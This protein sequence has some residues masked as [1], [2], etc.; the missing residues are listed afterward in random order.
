MNMGRFSEILERFKFARWS[1]TKKIVILTAVGISL[2]LFIILISSG[3]SNKPSS[4]NKVSLIPRDSAPKKDLDY[5]FIKFDTIKIPNFASSEDPFAEPPKN[6]E[7]VTFTENKKKP[8]IETEI[9]EKPVQTTTKSIQPAPASPQQPISLQQRSI[10]QNPKMIVTNNL[11]ANSIQGGGSVAAISGMQSVLLKVVLPERTPVANGS[12]VEARVLR[13][14]KW[15]NVYIPKRTKVIGTASLYNRRVNIDFQEIFL[16]NTS[17]SCRGRAYDLKRLQGIE[18]SPVNSEAKRVLV[19]ELRDAVSGVPVLG[20]V[21]N[22]ATY[23]SN[24]YNQ[25]VSVLDE[26]LEFYVM[27]ESIY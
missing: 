13:D 19:E 10:N 14:A 16:N 3:S 4:F 25:D 12:L 5:E 27:I 9:L 1:K 24:Y 11:S 8:A 22:R 2:L 15:G 23:S 21:A 26:G 7:S 20:R 6:I 18:Y 17:R